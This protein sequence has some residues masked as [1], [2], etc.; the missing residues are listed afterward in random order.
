MKRKGKIT[1][2]LSAIVA[3]GAVFAAWSILGRGTDSWKLV[4]FI[5]HIPNVTSDEFETMKAM[6]PK[7][8]H[9]LDEE[10]AIRRFLAGDD[11]QP[12]EPSHKHE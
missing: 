1:L 8:R 5:R 12:T 6:N 9:Q 4:H 11:S 3:A 7:S 10:E 2:V